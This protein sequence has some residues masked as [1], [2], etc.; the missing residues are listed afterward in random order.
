MQNNPSDLLD[1][2]CLSRHSFLAAKN[3]KFAKKQSADA[4]GGSFHNS[5]SDE[6]PSDLLVR[7]RL[8]PPKLL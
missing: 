8:R 5:K 4:C 6:S 1:R 3:A 7:G 2:G